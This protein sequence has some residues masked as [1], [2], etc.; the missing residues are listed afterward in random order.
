MD[1]VFEALGGLMKIVGILMMAFIIGSLAVAFLYII[2][3]SVL[4]KLAGC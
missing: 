4:F 1:T 3:Y 2:V